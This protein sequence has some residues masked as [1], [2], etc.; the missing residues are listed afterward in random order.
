[1]QANFEELADDLLN[2][3]VASD[4]PSAVEAHQIFEG[5]LVAQLK[6]RVQLIQILP[7][8]VFVQ[9]QL[10]MH[11]IFRVILFHADDGVI[12]AHQLLQELFLIPRPLPNW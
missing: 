7:N 3:L 8:K 2:I 9:L 10:E 5:Q 4:G 11:S 12:L 1:M 6:D